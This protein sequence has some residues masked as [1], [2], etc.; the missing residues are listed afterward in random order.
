MKSTETEIEVLKVQMQNIEKKVDEGFEA[1]IKRL[2]EMDG[3]FA[4]MWVKD[5]IVWFIRIVMGIVVTGIVY[6]GISFVK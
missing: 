2:D 4:P 3:K 6:A 1:V 5:A